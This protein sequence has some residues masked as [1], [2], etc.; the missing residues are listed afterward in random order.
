MLLAAALG[1]AWTPRPVVAQQVEVLP[2][3]DTLGL[4]RGRVGR[5]EYYYAD[6]D[7]ERSEALARLIQGAAI[8]FERELDLRFDLALAALG[9]ERWFSE[10]PGVPYAIPWV[11]I[12]EHVLMLPASLSE[13]VLV[14]GPTQLDDRRRVDFVALHEYGHLAAKEYFRPE[15]GPPYTPMSWFDELIATYFAYGYLAETDPVWAAAARAEWEAAIRAYRPSVVSLDWGF[16]DALPPREL[17]DTYGWYQTVLNRQAAEL[18]DRRG[19]ELLPRLKEALDWRS[20]SSWTTES[21]LDD[22]ESVAPDLAA[23][24][25]DFGEDAAAGA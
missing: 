22:L 13:G 18:F 7:R 2:V 5:V 11:S 8:H 4:E 23:W 20:A 24:A 15:A 9:P 3:L 25:R 19:I 10:F 6:P 17:S 16:M 21:L 14:Q 1:G 12:P